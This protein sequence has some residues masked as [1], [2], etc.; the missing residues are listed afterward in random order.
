MNRTA[1]LSESSLGPVVCQIFVV[2]I[3]DIVEGSL[4]KETLWE[5][6]TNPKA[7]CI[8]SGFKKGLGGWCALFVAAQEL[9]RASEVLSNA[10]FG[11]RATEGISK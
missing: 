10:S 11:T 9:W 8:H 1:Q 4:S 7:P 3:A 6:E 2:G 5:V